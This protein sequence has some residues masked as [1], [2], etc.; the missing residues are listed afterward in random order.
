MHS[1]W[2]WYFVKGIIEKNQTWHVY[3]PLQPPPFHF[4]FYLHLIC[5][6]RTR[7]T[8]ISF[9]LYWL[10]RLYFILKL[11]PFLLQLPTG[12]TQITI[13]VAVH[14][15]MG[16]SNRL[17]IFQQPWDPATDYT[18]FS[19]PGT[20]QQ[21]THISVALTP[22]NRL[23]IFHNNCMHYFK[24]AGGVMIIVIVSSGIDSSTGRV[25]PKSTKL[26]FS[27][28][29]AALRSKRLDGSKSG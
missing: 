20:Q 28:K 24:T 16:P 6:C 10:S 25:E 2:Y 26:V 23:H 8:K 14:K 11:S 9:W 27:A 29:H 1:Y 12:L 22:S 19:S 3:M 18:Y 7:W 4:F 21:T 5:T 13:S 17:H 15:F